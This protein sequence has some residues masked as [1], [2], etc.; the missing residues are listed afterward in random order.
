MSD[1]HELDINGGYLQARDKLRD[2]RH[3]TG[4]AQLALGD[5]IFELHH[6]LLTEDELLQVQESLG[7]GD[8]DD[9][10]VDLDDSEMQELQERLL[11]LQ[12][13]PELS[14]DEQA[15]L[16]QLSKRLGGEN[17]VDQQLDEDARETLLDLGRDVI[18]PSDED[19]EAVMSADPDTQRE[20]LGEIPTHLTRDD[21]R[22]A[23]KADMQE[24][25]TDQ[26]YPIKY[27]LAMQALSET[28]RVLGNGR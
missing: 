2:G 13:K 22:N 3:W 27:S 11:E 7:G 17:S 10:A 9:V 25:I 18:K 12:N 5:E 28:Q 1:D 21:V 23:L 6:R 24:M 15:E 19:V 16:K 14:E 8:D 4:T 26:P 20:I